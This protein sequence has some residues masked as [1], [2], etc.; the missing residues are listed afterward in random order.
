MHHDETQH[1]LLQLLMC[2]AGPSCKRKLLA[3]SHSTQHSTVLLAWHCTTN[4]LPQTA[5]LDMCHQLK[6]S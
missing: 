6:A 3:A 5:V 2:R 4:A 1:Y